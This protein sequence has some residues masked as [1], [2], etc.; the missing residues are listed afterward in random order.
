MNDDLQQFLDYF[1]LNKNNGW[2]QTPKVRLSLLQYNRPPITSRAE[3]NYPPSRVRYETLYLD[4]L[5][6]A[7][8]PEIPDAGSTS[9]QSDSWDDDG[10][11]FI[12]KFDHYTELIGHSKVKLHMSCDSLDDMDVY[13]ILRKLNRDGQAL[14]NCNIPLQFQKPGLT[15]EDIPDENIT[16]YVGPSGR[17]RASKRATGD[18]PDLTEELL[19]SREPTELWYPHNQSEKV[20]IGEIVELEIGIWPGGIVFEEG[21]AIRLEIKGHDP[22]LP[23]FPS[24]Y[25]APTNLN[26][27]R[28][29]IYTSNVYKSTILLPLTTS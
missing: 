3:D 23:E 29:N 25:R 14:L 28:H 21:E 18:D 15:E 1:L 8:V 12:H 19:R 7:L 24:L 27:G 22:I 10:A 6:S 2:D 11:H 13:V 5:N 4:A 20:P 17:L 26:Q 9:Y 16:K